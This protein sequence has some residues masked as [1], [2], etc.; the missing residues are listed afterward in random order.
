MAGSGALSAGFKGIA[1]DLIGPRE[2]EEDAVDYAEDQREE[3][4]ES[5]RSYSMEVS[6]ERVE[7]LWRQALRQKSSGKADLAAA[8]ATRSKAE[9]ER[10][11]MSQAALEATRHACRDL[12][13]EAE[14]QLARAKQVEAEAEKNLTEAEARINEAETAR[15]DADRYRETALADSYRE[16]VMAEAQQQ[17]QTARSEADSYR[18]KVTAE[19]QQEAQT[20]RSDADSYRE[21]VMAEAE[22]EAQ[23]IRDEA[24]AA[25]LQE[26]EELKRHVTY[27]VESIL[28]EI[29]TIREA[30][31]EE[32]ELSEYMLRQPTSGRCLKMSG[33]RSWTIWRAP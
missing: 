31:Q 20:A 24:R 22:Q 25:T 11:Q 5:G 13:A 16:K 33:H 27:E 29:D 23:R 6:R 14:R 9:M 30:A 28:S 18:D 3:Q 12:I 7:T 2:K 19:T 4:Q 21:K 1:K 8:K 10:Q 15:L 17:A 32:L 26:C